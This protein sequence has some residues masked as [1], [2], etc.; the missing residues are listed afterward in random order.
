MGR[1]LVYFIGFWSACLSVL[2]GAAGTQASG[3]PA[4]FVS[5]APQ[6]Y[7]VERI[8]GPDMDIS[9]MVPTGA[10]PATYEPKPRQ[11]VALSKAALYFAVG[12]PFERVWL[13]K[14]SATHPHLQVIHTEAGIAKRDMATHEHAAALGRP[15][16]A[17]VDHPPDVD[18]IEDPHVWTAP[19]LVIVQARNILTALMA[20]D[21]GQSAVYLKNY[22]RFVADL[23][24]LDTELLAAFAAHPAQREFIVFHPSWGYFADAYG[25][26]QVCIEIEGKAPKPAQLQRL[27]VYARERGI[28]V[29]FVQPQFST[30]SAQVIAK[31]IGGRV[32]T[33]DPLAADW[34]GNLRRQTQ[35]FKAAMR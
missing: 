11:M 33:A 15:A 13:P 26:R 18:R 14:I 25:L 2:A 9:V 35:K 10:S 30:Q 16:S 8:G 7:F 24:D 19:S 5:I 4:V 28:G 22:K 31:A 23:V 29:V 6:K 17:Q 12:V 32:I 21:P 1:S 34:F 3:K 20:A 27:I